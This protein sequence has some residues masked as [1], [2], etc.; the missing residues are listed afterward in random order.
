MVVGGVVDMLERFREGGLVVMTWRVPAV[1][2][3]DRKGTGGERVPRPWQAGVKH[4]LR[5]LSWLGQEREGW[6]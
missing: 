4:A 2:S 1:L 5:T 3:C 6:V